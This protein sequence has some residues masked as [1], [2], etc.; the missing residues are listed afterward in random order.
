MKN[1]QLFSD[2]PASYPLLANLKLHCFL[3]PPTLK[4]LKGDNNLLVPL[5][6]LSEKLMWM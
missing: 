3:P 6:P 2:K 5:M 4:K 1:A